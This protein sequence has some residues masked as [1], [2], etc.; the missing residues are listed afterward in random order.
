MC[1]FLGHDVNLMIEWWTVKA[2]W[3]TFSGAPFTL[4]SIYGALLPRAPSPLWEHLVERRSPSEVFT[5]AL[6]PRAP[7]P[8][9]PWMVGT[10]SGAPF[11]LRSIYGGVAPPRTPPPLVYGSS[12]SLARRRSKVKVKSHGLWLRS[13]LIRMVTRSDG[14]RFS[15]E[16]S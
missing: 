12:P 5:G 16:S 6:L 7:P 1:E 15:I 9:H 8:L 11:T 4:R 2:A 13:G 10:F 14:L 3:W